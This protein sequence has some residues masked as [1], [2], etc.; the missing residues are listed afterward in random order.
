RPN[1][2]LAVPV[3]RLTG[4]RA[5][6]LCPGDRVYIDYFVAG[7]E[8]VAECDG[9]EPIPTLESTDAIGRLP[10]ID[11]ATRPRRRPAPADTAN[12]FRLP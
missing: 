1:S 5:G 2:L 3:D 6:P 11:E 8:P 9:S 12:P 4:L 10:G 7:T